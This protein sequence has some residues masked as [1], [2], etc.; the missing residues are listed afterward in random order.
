MQNACSLKYFLSLQTLM[1]NRVHQSKE[2]VLLRKES[3]SFSSCG[4]GQLR[5]ETK[6]KF[7]INL[8]LKHKMKNSG[9]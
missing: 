7:Q 4:K 8:G 6:T 9:A 3:T 2:N 1:M 5:N